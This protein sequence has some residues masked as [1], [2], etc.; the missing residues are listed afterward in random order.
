MKPAKKY[1][2]KHLARVKQWKDVSF[3]DR[4]IKSD[5]MLAGLK[6]KVIERKKKKKRDDDDY[7]RML[8]D[9]D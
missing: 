3:E 6:K 8:N 5:I 4:K 9:I 2:K 1:F 7:F